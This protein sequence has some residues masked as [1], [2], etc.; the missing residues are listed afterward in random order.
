MQRE[1]LGNLAEGNKPLELLINNE[2]IKVSTWQDVFIKLLKYIMNTNTEEFNFIIEN[3]TLLFSR[4][5]VIV[6]WS[7]LEKILDKKFELANRY[8][9]FEGQVWDKVNYLDYSTWFL[10]IN[11]S[12]STCIARVANIMNKLNMDKDSVI[13]TLK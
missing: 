2:K 9:S 11:I 8:K 5:D 13:I 4:E 10:H 7:T 12:A 3:Q 6:T 1:L